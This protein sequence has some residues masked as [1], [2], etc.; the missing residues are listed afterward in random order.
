M[1]LLACIASVLLIGV[2]IGRLT[3]TASE[4]DELYL[5]NS[6]PS[7]SARAKAAL[8]EARRERPPLEHVQ[9]FGTPATPEVTS[10]PRRRRN[11]STMIDGSGGGSSYTTLNPGTA[12]Q[13]DAGPG[14]PGSFAGMEAEVVRLVN[15]QRASSGCRPLRIDSRLVRSARVHATE[16]AVSGQ[17]TH[18]SP[19]GTTPWQRMAAAGYADSGA[20]TIARG[21]ETAIEVV[22]GWMAGPRDRATL[23][24]CRLV[25]TGVGVSTGV[26][27]L[28]WTE[29]FGYS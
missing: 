8:A 2:V 25:A 24:N 23:L 21:Y 29:D 11:P 18:T 5:R 14:L 4:P 7:P 16:M 9:R 1:G 10:S 26:D 27:G 15:E 20:E 3:A 17:F 6:Q 19:G 28:W 12:E 22:R 13:G